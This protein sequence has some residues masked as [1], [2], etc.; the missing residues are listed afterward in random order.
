MTISDPS[1]FKYVEFQLESNEFP[2][3]SYN[4]GICVVFNAE[5]L[6]E[7]PTSGTYSCTVTIPTSQESGTF[8][9][10]A[11]VK[12][13]LDNRDDRRFDSN[14]VTVTNDN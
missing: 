6:D 3:P 8:R 9:P 13:I 12:D 2:F 7:A 1:K 14:S 4:P 10:R 11:I 5:S